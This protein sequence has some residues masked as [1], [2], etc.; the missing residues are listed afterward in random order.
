M[1]S[2]CKLSQ[3]TDLQ[4]TTRSNIDVWETCFADVFREYSVALNIK[5]TFHLSTGT[6]N[7]DYI[8]TQFIFHKSVFTINF[9]FALHISALILR[10]R[11]VQTN[12]LGKIK[13]HFTLK[14]FLRNRADCE[15]MW[16]NIV[17]PGRPQKARIAICMPDKRGKNTDTYSIWSTYRSSTASNATLTHFIVSVQ[18]HCLDVS[19]HNRMYEP[20]LI[21]K[22]RRIFPSKCLSIAPAEMSNSPRWLYGPLEDNQ[23]PQKMKA[24]TFPLDFSLRIIWGGVSRYA[25]TP[26]TFALPPIHSEITSFRPWSPIATGNYLFRAEKIPNLPHTTGTVDICVL[27]SGISGTTSRRASS[28]PNLHEIWTQPAHE[29][30]QAAQLLIKPKYCGLPWLSRE[31]D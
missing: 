27:R 20:K 30:C 14:D 25:F 10:I 11:N 9:E 16:K 13:T 18:V 19:I 2:S 23:W 24:K 26:L 6:W 31:F 28:C 8:I 12:G 22:S 3:L 1:E 4:G 21:L 15:I 17:E 29:R 5:K 7:L